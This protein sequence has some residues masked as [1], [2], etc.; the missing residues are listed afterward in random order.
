MGKKKETVGYNYYASFGALICHGPLD[1]LDAIWMD[2]ELVW[3]GPLSRSG[4]YTDITIENRGTVRLYWGTETQTADPTLAT[5]GVAH[6]TYRGQAYLVFSQL[7][8]G[9]NRTNAPSIEVKVRRWPAP[10][11]LTAPVSI[12]D[13]ASPVAVLWDLFTNPR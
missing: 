2:D 5:S 6:P 8:F 12:Q 7:F 9:L 13:D 1:R 4:D 3:Q 10:S 11:W